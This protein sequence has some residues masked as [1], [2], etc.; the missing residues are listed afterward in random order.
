ML[1]PNRYN[2]NEV[3][4]HRVKPGETLASIARHYGFKSWRPIWIYNEQ[5]GVLTSPGRIRGGTNIFIPRSEAGYVRLIKKFEVLKWQM[6]G[7]G[8]REKYSLDAEHFRLKAFS[9]AVD[10]WAEALT[11]LATLGLQ[12]VKAARMLS[13]AEKM[14]GGE[15]V[16]AEYLARRESEK[17]TEKMT[18]DLADKVKEMAEDRATANLGEEQ[19]GKA[20]LTYD[21]AFKTVPKL[22]N[23]V[24]G[25]SLQGGKAL[26][27]IS[28]ILLDYAKPSTVADFVVAHLRHQ[29]S[30]ESAYERSRRQIEHSVHDSCLRLEEKRR[31]IDRERHLLYH[32]QGQAEPA[33]VGVVLP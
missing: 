24:R 12:A 25:F 14:A 13:A 32:S 11:T 3:V 17:L 21:A 20:D 7:F 5:R 31:Q 33:S 10:A 1:D 15:R 4:I 29:G 18:E 23:A 6:Q 30:A 8:D 19:K 26:L 9:V 28:E 27:D 16:A 2:G 22:V